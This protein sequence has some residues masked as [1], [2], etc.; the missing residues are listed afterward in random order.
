MATNSNSK[1][2]QAKKSDVMPGFFERGP[3][4]EGIVLDKPVK[5]S[6]TPAKKSGASGTKKK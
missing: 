1:G 4:G 5:G 3:G 6:K 2:R